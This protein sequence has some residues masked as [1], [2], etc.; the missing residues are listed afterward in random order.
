MRNHTTVTVCR[1]RNCG[2]QRVTKIAGRRSGVT[3]DLL[4]VETLALSPEGRIGA[5]PC[6]RGFFPLLAVTAV[7]Q[8]VFA[9]KPHA[10]PQCFQNPA[11]GFKTVCQTSVV[12][13]AADRRQL[14]RIRIHKI[15]LA[16]A[17]SPHTPLP[18]PLFS[19][20]CPPGALYF[21]HELVIA[22]RL[23]HWLRN[24]PPA[25]VRLRRRR[26]LQQT[27]PLPTALSSPS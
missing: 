18:T 11:F 25:Q 22:Q 9:G 1:V 13:A 27:R 14:V 24:P 5:S 10:A 15:E 23:P 17:T 8:S 16:L 2:N 26:F 12:T 19:H 20:L 6:T 3:S 7:D 21:R 4:A